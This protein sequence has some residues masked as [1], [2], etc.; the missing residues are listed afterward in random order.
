MGEG[1]NEYGELGDGFT[2]SISIFPEQMFPSPQPVL[3]NNISNKTNLQ[4]K[5][6]CQFGGK[7]YLLTGT[8]LTQPLSQWTSVATNA[9]YNRTNNV[10]KATLTN[11]ANASAIQKFYILR[12]Q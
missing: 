2:N 6:L 11:A 12:S 3:T 7:F 4:F 5:A 8:N 9:I 1:D 10:F